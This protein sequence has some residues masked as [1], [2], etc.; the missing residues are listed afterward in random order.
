MVNLQNVENTG[1]LTKV[2]ILF[3]KP[4]LEAQESLISA[5]KIRVPLSK[6]GFAIDTFWERNYQF[7]LVENE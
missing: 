6:K 2:W 3:E 5:R 1:T 7:I 4:P